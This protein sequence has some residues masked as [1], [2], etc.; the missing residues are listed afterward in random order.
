MILRLLWRR[1]F[2]L[3][4]LLRLLIT[5]L[6][7]MLFFGT[8]IH[9]IE[10]KQFPTIFDGIWWAFVTGSTVGYG[11]FVPIS[12]IGK[13]I[14]ILMILTGGGV[15]TYYMVTISTETVRR[16]KELEQG[17]TAFKECD[18]I[19]LVGWNERTKQLIKMIK[20]LVPNDDVV[21]IDN[22]LRESPRKKNYHFHFI[23]G[24]ASHDETLQ[25]A[26]IQKAKCIVITA[27]QSKSERQA[28]Q[29]AILMTVAARGLNPKI[30]IVTEILTSDQIANAKRAGAN[31]V[32]RSND[33][34]ST[35]FFHEMYRSE[36]IKPFDAIVKQL[37]S[38]QYN[39]Y[40]LPNTL[41]G[42]SFVECCTIYGKQNELL[43][44]II[45]EGKIMINPPSQIKLQEDDHLI[46]LTPLRK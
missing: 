42:T 10:P 17:K 23:R 46:V 29:L 36:P 40:V 6:V 19:I 2:Q 34:M 16:E 24:D 21:L 38:Q 28:D 33:F 22:T 9:F 5:V 18:H 39:E 37:E 14:G 12:T 26:N 27:D 43:I 8:I 20:D 7:A 41:I 11:D 32:I 44:G 13:L 3:P 4:L 1:Y 31:T 15:L 35:L 30:S 45:R 25:K